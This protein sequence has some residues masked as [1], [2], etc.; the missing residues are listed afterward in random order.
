MNV[1]GQEDCR[2]IIKELEPVAHKWYEIGLALGLTPNSLDRLKALAIGE[3]DFIKLLTSMIVEWLRMRYN[4]VRFG[5]PTWR[6]I[7]EAVREDTGGRNPAL[8]DELA[9]NYGGKMHDQHLLYI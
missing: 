3:N 8:A 2:D 6:R 5:K 7:V 4:T 1:L 9:K